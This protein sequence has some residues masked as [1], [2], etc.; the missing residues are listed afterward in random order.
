MKCTHCGIEISKNQKICT[1]CG[2]IL[3]QDHFYDSKVKRFHYSTKIGLTFLL[4]LFVL[5]GFVYTEISNILTLKKITP[6]SE[7]SISPNSIHFVNQLYVSDYRHY[8]YLLDDYQKEI[9]LNLLTAIKNYETQITIDT[10]KIKT[11]YVSEYLLEVYDC[12]MMDHPEMLHLGSIKTLSTSVDNKSIGLTYIL[13]KEE[14]KTAINDITIII[15]KI[16]ND[17]K[18]MPDFEKAKYIYEYLSKTSDYDN[19]NALNQSAYSAI[20]GKHNS[21]Y[22][23]YARASQILLQNVKLDS[24]ITIGSVGGNTHA[25]NL[26]KL[27]NN[28]YYFDITTSSYDNEQLR[29]N[30]FLKNN[31]K[32]NYIYKKLIPKI[33]NS[34][35]E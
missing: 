17:I 29:Y 32:Y 26:I 7:L 1:R 6:I 33:K 10:T 14:L 15:S 3:N 16:K 24:I 34:Y 35:H 13:T 30:G 28:Y 4:I 9:Y 21:N 8:T 2:T 12:L 18:D 11:R 22:L 5:T 27:Q 20:T 19:T 31:R 25:W 23:G